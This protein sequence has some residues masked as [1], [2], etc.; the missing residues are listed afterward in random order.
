MFRISRFLA[1]SA[2]AAILWSA[3]ASAQDMTL[4]LAHVAPAESSYQEAAVRFR[5]KLAELSGGA[6]TVDIVPGSALG[7]MGELWVQT[8]SSEI[9]L[10]LIDVAAVIAM[11]EARSFLVLW[12][13]YLFADQ[14]HFHRFLAS[15]IFESMTEALQRDTGIVYLGFVGDRSPRV[16]TTRD[17]PVVTPSDL[18]GL[19]IRTPE[20]P[21]II[22]AFE[23]W[24]AVPTPIPASELFMALQTGVVDGQDNG[25][26]DFVGP[27]FAEVNKV[28]AP[29][30]FIRSGL[31]LFMSP[32]RWDGLSEEQRGWV[33]EAAAHAGAVGSDLYAQ[34][35]ADAMARLEASGITVTEPDLEAFRQAVQPMIDDL[36]GKAW[37]EGL[38]QQISDL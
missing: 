13:P 2:L 11:Q 26:L 24:G 17:K 18:A 30:D 36:D 35:V 7:N 4:T 5:E 21:F 19:K 37:P 8:R 16:V 10:H 3:Q 12:A 22:R 14:E 31:G 20:H 6:I 32:G 38:Y 34:Q 1:S 25:L 23:S 15:D 33:R 27:G 28:F 9:D 29:I